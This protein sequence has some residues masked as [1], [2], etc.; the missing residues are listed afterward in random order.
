MRAHLGADLPYQQRMA[1]FVENHDEPRAVTA[2]GP[3]LFPALVAI[4]TLPGVPFLHEGQLEGRRVHVPVT[5][6]RR[7]DEP[8]SR[9]LLDLHDRVL[10]HV[11]TTR[12]REGDWRLCDVEG[13]PDNASC[14]SLVA[15]C[16]SSARGR[17]A[18]AVNLSDAIA[19]G[20]IRLPWSDLRGRTFTF[21]DALRGER[22]A[23]S[24]DELDATG[25]YV[26]LPP[27]G[28]HV[29]TLGQ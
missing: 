6:R 8:A 1:R 5:L 20:R 3:R 13:W 28:A 14:A 17:H 2:L 15:W 23:R 10:R 7:P 29:L 16:W 18:I 26:R 21:E 11:A 19:D 24:G 22:Y 25:L 4:A 9:E 12:M 27:R